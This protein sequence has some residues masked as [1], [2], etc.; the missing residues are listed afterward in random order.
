MWPFTQSFGAAK[1]P[2]PPPLDKRSSL[3]G[4]PV[5]NESVTSETRD[6]GNLTV[7]VSLKRGH[8]ILARFQPRKMERPYRLDELGSFV[9]RQIDGKRSARKIVDAFAA[10]YKVNR[11]EAELSV[12]E[13]IKMLTQR[14]AISIVIK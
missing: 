7:T 12:V 10:R 8:G 9:W 11:R 13:F 14:Q 1:K 5:V 6:D 2:A 3:A 4:I